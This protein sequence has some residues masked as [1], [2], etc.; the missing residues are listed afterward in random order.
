MKKSVIWILL[1]VMC[2]LI[3]GCGTVGEKQEESIET[4]DA[5]TIENAV[6]DDTEHNF[7]G[8]SFEVPEG[9]VQDEEMS[10]LF[11]SEA[12]AEDFA[13][14]Y[15]Q[16]ADVDERY[17]LLTEESIEE[18]MQEAYAKSYG[19]ETV[20]DVVDFHRFNLDGYEAYYTECEYTINEVPIQTVEYA[21]LTE[22]RVFSVTYMQKQNAGW[23][24]AFAQSAKNLE[25][26]Q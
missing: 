1:S 9:F 7:E 17:S 5:E 10:G 15:Y 13:C 24:A 22:T 3:A 21:V 18:L 19:M 11:V 25:I 23:K 12:Y 6:E 8:L 2:L 20:I 16:E 4:A 26:R 14:I